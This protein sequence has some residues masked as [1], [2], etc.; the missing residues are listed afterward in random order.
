MLRNFH[1]P[2]SRRQNRSLIS[3]SALSTHKKQ[4]LSLVFGDDSTSEKHSVEVTKSASAANGK[5][6]PPK[7]PNFNFS[8]QRTHAQNKVLP[9]TAN[10]SVSF[11]EYFVLCSNVNGRVKW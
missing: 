4:Q 9:N 5:S 10:D 11:V 1:V 2:P 7:R 6:S 3:H 8:Q